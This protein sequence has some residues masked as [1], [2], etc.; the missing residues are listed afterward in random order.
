MNQLMM[1]GAAGVR[2]CDFST[3]VLAKDKRVEPV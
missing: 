2:S 3:A 1:I